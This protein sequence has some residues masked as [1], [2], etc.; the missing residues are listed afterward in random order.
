MNQVALQC[1]MCRDGWPRVQVGP[2]HY[3]HDLPEPAGMWRCEALF[4]PT[5]DVSMQ[6]SQNDFLVYLAGPISG[7][8]FD[9]AADWRE[10][11]RERLARFGI[12]AL[13]PL[14][15]KEY[16]RQLGK[17]ISST[18]EDYAHLGVLSLPRGVMTR[19]RYDATR[20]DVLLVNLAG[21]KSVSIG[22]VMEI[23]WA[24]NNRIPIVAIIEP[25]GNV[26][27][28]MMIREALGFT[29]ET[30]EQGIDLVIAISGNAKV[31]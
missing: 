15:G 25:R 18:G 11:A 19:D 3:S 17:P 10:T 22:T 23:A 26:H 14:R 28:H 12:K 9:E 6:S 27:E 2:G 21:A 16:L 5:G 24:D 29:A 20:C 7:L 8:V 30:L 13:S 31:A 1:P 4:K